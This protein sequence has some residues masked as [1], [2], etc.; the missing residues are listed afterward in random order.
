MNLERAHVHNTHLLNFRLHFTN[1]ATVGLG[2]LLNRIEF[3]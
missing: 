2:K 1:K 3:H